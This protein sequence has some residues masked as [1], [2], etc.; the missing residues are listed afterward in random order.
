MRRVDQM[1]NI[2]VSRNGVVMIA[3]LLELR[4]KKRW[5]NPNL[6]SWCPESL[7]ENSKN[8]GIILTI[9]VWLKSELGR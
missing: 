2:E 1:L 5:Q 4:I 8:A 6:G 9:P 3:I 7:F